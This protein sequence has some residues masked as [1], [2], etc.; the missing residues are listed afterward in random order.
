[1]KR[2]RQFTLAFAEEVPMKVREVMTE[3]VLTCAPEAS[4]ATAAGLMREADYGTLPVV[5]VHGRLAGI[6][7]DR[8]ICL[9]MAG[10]HRNALNI[11][12]HEVMTHKVFSA[13]VDDEVRGALTTMKSKRVRRLPVCDAT[14]HLKGIVSIEDVIL[15]GLSGGGIGASDIVDALR[16]MNVRSPTTVASA[17]MDNSGFTPG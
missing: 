5:D 4:L 15:R 13:L 10:S 3:P 9:A 6:I 14:G 2:E 1:L 17:Q 8:D 7:T 11:T 16:V 12:V